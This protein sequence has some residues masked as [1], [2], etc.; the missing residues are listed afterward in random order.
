MWRDVSILCIFQFALIYPE[1]N[2]LLHRSHLS[3]DPI[4]DIT[5]VTQLTL[6]RILAV[7]Y[8]SIHW[9]G[10]ISV[11]LYIPETRLSDLHEIFRYSQT[12][13]RTY[14]LAV[15]LVFRDLVCISIAFL[16]CSFTSNPI[17]VHFV[18][19][20]WDIAGTK[21]WGKIQDNLNIT[22]VSCWHKI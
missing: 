1:I 17:W 6:D 15:H 8:H 13:T 11:A 7:E 21:K 3:I 14:N 18:K 9:Q 19:L 12:L 16:K 4:Q 10:P 22:S 5:L 20:H 2:R